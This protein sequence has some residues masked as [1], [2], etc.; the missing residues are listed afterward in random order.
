M[1]KLVQTS[2]VLVLLL[3]PSADALA[4][5]TRPRERSARLHL[6]GAIGVTAAFQENTFLAAPSIDA[7]IYAPEGLGV[8]VRI[9]YEG[10]LYLNFGVLDLGVAVRHEIPCGDS[11]GFGLDFAAGF[12]GMIRDSVYHFTGD[13]IAFA[14]FGTAGIDLRL[15]SLILGLDV[16]TRWQAASHPIEGE[17]TRDQGEWIE[18]GASIRIG[19]EVLL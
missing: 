19:G 12:S 13:D 17:P 11:C 18:L 6:T 7:R 4:E 2:L 8:I 5:D 15:G 3:A 1:Q 16:L 9:G 10:L 14:L